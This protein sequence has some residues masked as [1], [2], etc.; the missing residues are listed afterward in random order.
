MKPARGAQDK[1]KR[2][3]RM[4][5]GNVLEN[6]YYFSLNSVKETSE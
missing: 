1:E 4:R 3:R 6:V 2:V 5:Y